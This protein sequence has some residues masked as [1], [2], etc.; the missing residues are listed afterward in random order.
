M[1][2]CALLFD[3]F[4]LLADLEE[5]AIAAED[6][7]RVDA[8]ALERTGLLRQIWQERA[9]CDKEKLQTLLQRANEYQQ[10]LTEAA[11]ALHARYREQ[12][13][14]GRKQSRYFNMDRHIQADLQKSF[15]CDKVS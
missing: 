3:K 5:E 2:K 14:N 9:G 8:L 15:Y 10:K 12:Q 1:H 7:D 11:R 4:F 13:R 6:M